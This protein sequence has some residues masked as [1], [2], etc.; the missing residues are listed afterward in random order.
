MVYPVFLSK[1]LIQSGVARWLP[2]VRRLADGAGPFLH[3]YSDRVLAAPLDALREAACL[4][5]AAGADGIDLSLG[6]PVFDLVPSGSTKLPVD[7]RSWPPV[8]GVPALREAVAVQLK[9]MHDLTV[10]PS[11]EVLITQGVSGAFGVALDSLINPGSRVALFDPTS[12]LYPLALRQRRARIRWIPSWMEGG[13]TRFHMDH[14]LKALRWARMIVLTSPANPTGGYLAPEDLEQIA[15]WADRHDVLIFEDRA[16][17]RYQYEGPT[18]SIATLPR[19]RARTLVAGSVSKGYGLAST[20]VGWLSGHRHLLRPCALTSLLQMPFVPTIAQ[21]IALTALAQGDEPFRPIL[22][23][24]ESRRR[25]AFERL[26]AIGLTPAWPAG[27]FFLWVN[28]K[29]LAMSGQAFRERLFQACKVL[30]TPGSL[31][32]PSG[33]DH[34]R[35]SYATDDGRFREG[36]TRLAE[37]VRQPRPTTMAKAA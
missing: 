15:W 16:F 7:R 13:R 3:Y 26:Q 9:R 6:T 36:L 24:F 27:A 37:F 34:V 29:H 23:E 21:H 4:L 19:A 18:A 10:Q 20:R 5:N 2:G 17:D 8:W 1:L 28:V 35:I 32:G 25:Y 31:F 12:P 22:A 33:G 14:L 30:V 11:D